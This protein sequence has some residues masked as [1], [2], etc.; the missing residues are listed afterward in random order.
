M[1]SQAPL[2]GDKTFF[3]NLKKSYVDV[4]VDPTNDNAISTTEF[5]EATESLVTM[6]GLFLCPLTIRSFPD[7]F[8]NQTS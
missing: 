8:Y 2:S 6:F 4:R 1:A 3:D 5:L 7:L